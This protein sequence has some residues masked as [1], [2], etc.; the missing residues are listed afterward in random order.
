[1][2]IF[3]TE[4]LYLHEVLSYDIVFSVDDGF[5][6][7]TSPPLTITIN[8]EK[9]HFRQLANQ[10][11]YLYP[12]VLQG[13]WVLAESRI[14]LKPV[15]GGMRTVALLLVLMNRLNKTKSAVFLYCRFSLF[16][17]DPFFPDY[18]DSRLS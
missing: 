4:D 7:V 13:Y 11:V 18:L 1:M 5:T 12:G 14:P 8:G 9:F 16:L 15:L 17:K 10:N 2:E 3:T 6:T